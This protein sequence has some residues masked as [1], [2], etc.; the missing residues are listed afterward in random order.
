MQKKI[1]GFGLALLVSL[2]FVFTYYASSAINSIARGHAAPFDWIV[3]SLA[4]V[5]AFALLVPM[6]QAAGWLVILTHKTGHWATARIEESTERSKANA[7]FSSLVRERTEDLWQTMLMQLQ[8]GLVYIT[9]L[10]GLEI[11]AL[12]ATKLQN[13]TTQQTML[14]AEVKRPSLIDTIAP[15][16]CVLLVGARGKGKTTNMLRL[17]E[18]RQDRETAIVFDTHAAPNKWPLAAHVYGSEPGMSENDRLGYMWARMM[19]LLSEMDNRLEQHRTTGKTSFSPISIYIDEFTRLPTEMKARLGVDLGQDFTFRVLNEGRKVKMHT[20]WGVHSDRAS[21]VGLKGNY[22]LM[23]SFDA[24]VHLKGNLNVP[25]SDVY[26]L[27]DLGDGVDK[28]TQYELARPFGAGVVINSELIGGQSG[29]DVDFDGFAPDVMDIG[30]ISPSV[31]G[32]SK[33]AKITPE[34]VAE[35]YDQWTKDNETAPTRADIA[36]ILDVSTGGGN[37]PKIDQILT[38]LLDN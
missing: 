38:D 9:N 2:F 25:S 29:L 27:L 6:L 1:V 18:A 21:A 35:A 36:K 28:G 37:G 19:W 4:A 13:V 12:P 15:L 23:R 31:D 17:Q 7:A 32:R 34:T 22:D 14:P 3:A 16:D 20:V 33:R 24:I 26:A 10:A 30:E 8:A 11:G 5:I